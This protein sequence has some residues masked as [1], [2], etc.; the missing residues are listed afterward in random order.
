MMVLTAFQLEV[1]SP[2]DPVNYEPDLEFDTLLPPVVTIPEPIYRL[3]K[4]PPEQ[5]RKT[6][7]DPL[8]EITL[9]PSDRFKQLNLTQTSTTPTS[10]S[11]EIISP[12]VISN[13]NKVYDFPS[14][15]PKYPGGLDAF[16]KFVSQ[17]VVLPQPS[18]FDPDEGFVMVSFVVDRFGEVTAVHADTSNMSQ[19]FRNA[20]I[21]AVKESDSW[22]PGKQGDRNVNVRMRIPVVFKFYD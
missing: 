5:T 7:F 18:P 19:P 17:E 11:N 16:R 8:S 4:R 22:T 21:K 13:P 14:R 20:A 2:E 10:L 9:V 1:V 6:P 3:K 12:R 15:M